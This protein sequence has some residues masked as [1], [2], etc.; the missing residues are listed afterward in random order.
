MVLL[1]QLAMVGNEYGQVAQN[2][3][4]SDP[5][6]KFESGVWKERV[7]IKTARV[8][9]EEIDDDESYGINER[10]SEDN[11]EPIHAAIACI[12]DLRE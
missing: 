9:I 6:T 1:Y 3:A 10:E 5:D 2:L 4:T 11:D 8:N 12:E 7:N